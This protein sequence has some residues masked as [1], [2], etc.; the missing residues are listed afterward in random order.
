MESG[1]H[2]FIAEDHMIDLVGQ[3]FKGYE[4]RELIGSGGFASVYRAYQSEIGREVALKVILPEFANL[5]EFIRRFELEAH[6]I[7]RLEHPH[8]VPLYDFWRDPEGAYLVMRWLRGGNLGSRILAG[9]LEPSRIALILDQVASALAAA[10]RSGVI[11][12]DIKPDNILLDDEGNAYLADFGIAK[13]IAAPQ[14]PSRTGTSPQTY[15]TSA[16]F[17]VGS[18]AYIS[19]EQARSVQDIS[20]ASDIYSLGITLFEM[21]TGQ[22]P[23]PQES[24]ISDLLE[25]HIKQPVPSIRKYRIDLP[26]PVDEVIQ[27]A[28]TKEP[29]GRYQ[30]AT[31]FAQAFQAALHG[32]SIS[33]ERTEIKT[34]EKVLNPYKGLRAFEESDAPQFFG[35]ERSVERLITRIRQN[36]EF[37]RFLAVVG[38]S[39]SG[40]SSLVNAGLL[41]AL[42]RGNLTGSGHWFYATFTPGAAPLYALEEALLRIA[43]LQPPNL[44]QMLT[45]DKRGL[46]QAAERILP[47]DSKTEV[48]LVIDQFEELFTLTE[49]ESARAHFLDLL[50]HAVADPA[51]RMR[52]VMIIR[53]DFMDRPL[54]YV[55]FGELMQR[56]SEMVLPLSST[57]I[58][59]AIVRP[60]ERA[61]VFFEDDLVST[62]LNEV[63]DQP[64][65]L[66]L[67][68]FALTELFDH[69][70]GARITLNDYLQGGGVIGA[71]AR[72]AEQVYGELPA[73]TQ[74]L[75]RQIF[76][77]LVTLGE[78]AEDTRR[79]VS[80]AELV[81]MGI[82]PGTLDSILNLYAR[83]RLLTIDIDPISHAPTV[84]VAHEALIR[85]WERLRGWLSTSRDDLRLQR[86]LMSTAAEWISS[87]REPSFLASG[88][89]LAQFE[90]WARESGLNMSA[91]EVEYLRASVS[92]REVVPVE[93]EARKARELRIASRAAGFQRAAVLLGVVGLAAAVLTLLAFG[94]AG[95]AN[96]LA[97]EADRRAAAARAEVMIAAETLTP[98]PPTLTK[99]A[100][101]I[102][103]GNSRLEQARLTSESITNLQD[104]TGNAETAALLALRALEL[105]YVPLADITL[106]RSLERLYTE[107]IFVGHTDDVASLD[108]HPDNKRMVTGSTDKTLRLWDL[109]SGAE[110]RRYEGHEGPI[111]KVAF[112]PEGKYI[113]SVSEDKTVRLWDTESGAL[114]HT[115]TGHDGIINSAI[116]SPDGR[117]IVTTC[118]DNTVRWWDVQSGVEVRRVDLPIATL[119]ESFS[120]DGGL[121]AV[122]ADRVVYLFDGITGNLLREIKGVGGDVD[123]LA[124]THDQKRLLL[125]TRDAFVYLYEVESGNLL[126]RYEG[127]NSYVYSAKFS[128]DEKLILTGS[129]DGT[130]RLFDAESGKLLRILTGHT[131][132]IREVRFSP[133]QKSALTAS[134]DGTV[135]RFNLQFYHL[136]RQFISH[137]DGV[138]TANYSPDGHLLATGG[139]DLTVRLWEVATG[140]Q[141]RVFE[142]HTGSI[143]YVTFSPDGHYLLSTSRDGTAKLWDVADGTL[144]REFKG[145]EGVVYSAGFSP[146]GKTIVTAGLDTTARLWDVATGVVL[147]LFSG[148]T[149]LLWTARFFPD[150]KHILTTSFDKTARVW[151]VATGE[152][153]A[154]FSQHTAAV[155][156]GAI[157]PDG[158]MVLTG[159]ADRIGRLWDARTGEEIRMLSGHTDAIANVAFSREGGMAITYG[160][161]GSARL[162]SIETGMEIRRF[163][164]EAAINTDAFSPDN[165]LVVFGRYGGS[166]FIQDTDYRD[167][168]TYAC[169]RVFQDFTEQQRLELG[170]ERDSQTCPIAGQSVPTIPTATGFPVPVVPVWTALPSLTPTATSSPTPQ[171][172]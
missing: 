31:L 138:I 146:D 35:R 50:Y 142:G 163:P 36:E 1:S 110:L 8:I 140:T 25:M 3:I 147:K 108:L 109:A 75:V 161:D 44:T 120:P 104:I 84:E 13:D 94:Q 41:P 119:G 67:L 17:I 115:M 91:E 66:P 165:K 93:D 111:N 144:I 19:P 69:H 48:M 121:L 76:L 37:S 85:T 16:D 159:G 118:L 130:A 4:I 143:W 11:H 81:S 28:T 15:L 149:R 40:K 21:L 154:T 137:R 55:E 9:A 164:L 42:R 2:I 22:K 139:A 135:R 27:T 166:A 100:L 97:S 32:S 63:E 58:Q 64:G 83:H 33:P 6:V 145:H 34:P 60:A 156:G 89:K 29:G 151:D 168:I 77:R 171:S 114:L 14:T 126:R 148:H 61:G 152:T 107:Q 80:R 155:L 53:A 78:G 12:R 72:R 127:H 24:S 116:F 52:V 47:P 131:D 43:T 158:A 105:G 96:E 101:Q 98:I 153:T 38:A 170:L 10:H 102:R 65:A 39:G 54:R 88:L 169:T 122:G 68:Q 150:G 49:S 99:V 30:S 124:F 18:P 20:A 123:S 46:V 59:R 70:I 157:S 133:D 129:R 92:Q 141:L 117:F 82:A 45:Q 86:R 167:L 5:P 134:W 136:P 26:A 23:F 95:R 128:A 106:M 74:E 125:G 113:A 112:S 7:A 160:Q 90:A 56:R 87:G 103:D 162:W 71:L 57:E 73:E 62:I 51:S 132:A 172:F 79:R